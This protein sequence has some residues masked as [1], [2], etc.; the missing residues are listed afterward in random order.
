[1]QLGLRYA[2]AGNFRRSLL[3]AAA[4]RLRSLFASLGIKAIVLLPCRRAALLT[5]ALVALARIVLEPALVRHQASH[6][7]LPN[8]RLMLPLPVLAASLGA[9]ELDQIRWLSGVLWYYC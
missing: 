2:L 8:G 9:S 3:S 5:N 1:M 4:H 6:V 7:L